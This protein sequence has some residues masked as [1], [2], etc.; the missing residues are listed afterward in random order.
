MFIPWPSPATGLCAWLGR[1]NESRDMLILK[2]FWKS[3]GI[4]VELAI[5]L[6]EL[7]TLILA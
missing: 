5:D 6:K 7:V 4:L 2:K 3:T 1:A